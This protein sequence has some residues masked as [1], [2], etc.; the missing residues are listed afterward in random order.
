MYPAISIQDSE[1]LI[2]F[3]KSLKMEGQ[4]PVEVKQSNKQFKIRPW[5]RF[6]EISSLSKPASTSD[7]ANRLAS[8]FAYFFGNYAIIMGMVLVFACIAQPLLVVGLA[9]I[10]LSI[11]YRNTIFP[12]VATVL[13][14]ALYTGGFVLVW[15][16][17]VGLSAS[18]AHAF[19]HPPVS[20]PV[21]P[22]GSVVSPNASNVKESIW[23]SVDVL[24]QQADT[25]RK[26]LNAFVGTSS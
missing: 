19:L 7:A 16:L 26:R 2:N 8:N 4:G 10:T 9:T 3:P 18:L 15:A 5:E 14:V 20:A 23:N 21:E 13:I 6:L 11:V 1:L 22:A 25:L 17:F 12:L 24:S